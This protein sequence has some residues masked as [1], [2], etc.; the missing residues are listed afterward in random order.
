MTFQET[1]SEFKVCFSEGDAAGMQY[2]KGEGICLAKK[3]K[4]DAQNVEKYEFEIPDAGSIKMKTGC[5]C[6]YCGYSM[7]G[8]PIACQEGGACCCSVG[9]GGFVYESF[10]K[11]NCACCEGSSYKLC[12]PL[13]GD[14]KSKPGVEA[15]DGDFVCQVASMKG[16]ICFVF[17]GGSL[18][19]CTFMPKPLVLCGNKCQCCCCYQKM[20]CP[21]TP[22]VGGIHVTCCDKAVVGDG[23]GAMASGGGAQIVPGGAPVQ[24]ISD[25][26]SPP[27]MAAEMRRR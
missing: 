15:D 11:S 6:F 17:G 26:I 2:S 25:D 7:E 27:S 10:D 14:A 24:T 22:E 13:E 23:P 21:P 12:L 18:F 8:T 5:L 3:Q 20:A 16:K 1:F 4:I 9:S 19:K